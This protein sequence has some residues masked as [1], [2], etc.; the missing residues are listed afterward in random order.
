MVKNAW[1]RAAVGGLALGLLGCSSTAPTGTQA[2][3]NSVNPTRAIQATTNVLNPDA[4]RAALPESIPVAEAGKRLVKID[5]SQI[6]GLPAQAKAGAE[7]STQQRGWRGRGWRGGWGGLGWRGGWGGLGW[8]GLGWGGLGW[9]GGWSGYGWDRGW[10]DLGY[11]PY[12]T[13]YYPVG[14]NYYP[15]Y[16]HG[17]SY[18]PYYTSTG[19]FYSMPGLQV[20][21]V[22]LYNAYSYNW[23]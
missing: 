21:P 13:M 3:V 15:Y 9:G 18:H 19:T 7:R 2:P 23:Y 20:T 6:A 8:S 16:Q 1:A 12:V 17:G 5:A 14:S 22:G 4:L 10:G 11:F